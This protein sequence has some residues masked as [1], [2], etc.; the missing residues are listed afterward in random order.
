MRFAY[1]TFSLIASLGVLGVSIYHF[2]NNDNIQGRYYLFLAITIF[3]ALYYLL[4]SIY[5][6]RYKATFNEVSFV[7]LLP[8]SVL[9]QF[10]TKT[11]LAVEFDTLISMSIRGLS[12]GQLDLTIDLF[13]LAMAPYFFFSVLLLLRTYLRYPFIRLSGHSERGLPSKFVGLLISAGISLIFRIAGLL[14]LSNAMLVFFAL[15]YGSMGII[16]FFA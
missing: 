13:D 10:T 11:L 2:I 9:I 6:L 3:I 15:F 16:G 12:G 14:F 8:I 5:Y 4:K 1:T 7:I